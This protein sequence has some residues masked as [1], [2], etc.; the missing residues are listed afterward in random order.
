MNTSAAAA[1]GVLKSWFF[2]QMSH[3]LSARI[4]ALTV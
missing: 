3:L 2:V 1:I 4:V